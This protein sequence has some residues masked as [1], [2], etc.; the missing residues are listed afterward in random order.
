[1][2]VK[3]ALQLYDGDVDLY[4]EILQTYADDIGDQISKMEE[5]RN[6]EDYKLL[7]VYVHGIK[8]ASRSIGASVLSTK[9]ER[10]EQ[11]AKK[12]D[13]EVIAKD[14]PGFIFELGTVMSAIKEYLENSLG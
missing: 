4:K 14:Y 7:A 1:M 6:K 5:A 3:K 9:S 2:D 8:S 13:T 11:A 12:G 10:L